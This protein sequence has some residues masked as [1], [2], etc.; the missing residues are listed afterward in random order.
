MSRPRPRGPVRIRAFT[1]LELIVVITIVGIL[2]TLVATNVT[3]WVPEGRRVAAR[4]DLRTIA[5]TASTLHVRSG[6]WPDAIEEMVVG[7][8][9]AGDIGLQTLPIDPW[10]HRY[11]YTVGDL[12]PIVVCYGRDGLPGGE[13]E[14]ADLRWPP[15]DT[16]PGR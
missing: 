16:G 13:G 15:D 1:L 3:R 4:T 11:E 6:R 12:G 10:G 5:E 9:S 8:E 14:D 2:G 7:S